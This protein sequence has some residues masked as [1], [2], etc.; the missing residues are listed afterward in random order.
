MLRKV[1]VSL[2]DR[3]L[4]SACVAAGLSKGIFLAR[5]PYACFDGRLLLLQHPIRRLDVSSSKERSNQLQFRYERLVISRLPGGTG[6]LPVW[7]TV[8]A[9]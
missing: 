9:Q 2:S 7:A 6:L 1:L 5:R 4:S 8:Q 3:T